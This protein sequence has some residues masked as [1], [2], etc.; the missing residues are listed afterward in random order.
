MTASKLSIED[1]FNDLLNEIEG[2]KY[3]ITVKV[4]LR[5]YKENGGNSTAKTVINSKYD[6]VKSFQ[7][8]LCMMDNWIN[9]GSGWIIE[10]INAEYVNI[11]IYSTLSGSLYIELTDKLR[12]SWKSLI[13]IKNNEC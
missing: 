13:N 1:L 4:L 5:K 12:N 2:F 9:E 10:S 8:I 7:E 3:Q 11:F 6:L